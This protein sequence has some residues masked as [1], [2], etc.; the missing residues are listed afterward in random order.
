MRFL[1]FKTAINLLIPTI[2]TY[3]ISSSKSHEIKFMM[4]RLVN[5]P[6]T[7]MDKFK[8]KNFLKNKRKK[9]NLE[10]KES[11]IGS[12][13]IIQLLALYKPSQ[14]RRLCEREF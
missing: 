8:T 12:L 10:R 11:Q 9:K 7:K 6:Q 5:L 14:L 13:G 4:L 3:S 1:C 2:L